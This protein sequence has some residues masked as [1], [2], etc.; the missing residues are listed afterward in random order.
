MITLLKLP[1]P[2]RFDLPLLT[3]LLSLALLI[4][5]LFVFSGCARKE[6]VKYG[7]PSETEV[8]GNTQQIQ[9]MVRHGY[10]PNHIAAKADM[11]LKLNF[12]RE[13][14]AG[15]GEELVIPSQ[16]IQMRLPAMNIR[17]VEIPPQPAGSV[18]EFHCG[19]NMLHG[20]IT[21]N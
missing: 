2:I 18:M 12:Y 1:Q 16:N 3:R 14:G 20:K 6:E 15:C 8:S 4:A 10:E 21:F 11:P 9:V 17:T 5:L 13:E 19:M 7:T